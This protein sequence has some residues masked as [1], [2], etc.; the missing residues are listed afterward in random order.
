MELNFRGKIISIGEVEQITDNFAKLTVIVEEVAEKYPQTLD[1]EIHK[2]KTEFMGKYGP[3]DILD[4]SC[5]FRTR[6]WDN[7]EG[8]TIFFKTVVCWRYKGVESGSP[9]ASAPQPGQ[10]KS[11]SDELGWPEGDSARYLPPD[12]DLPF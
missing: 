2:G 11:A 1:I 8:K 9:Q 7:R 3:G 4:F 5:N 10:Q 12:E 6:A